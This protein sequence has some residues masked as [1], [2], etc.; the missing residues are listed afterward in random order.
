MRTQVRL[1]CP[2]HRDLSW[3]T[4]E[5][6]EDYAGAQIRG[7]MAPYYCVSKWTGDD[8]VRAMIM[9]EMLDTHPEFEQLKEELIDEFGIE[10]FIGKPKP[11]EYHIRQLE[12]AIELCKTDDDRAKL[13]KELREYRGWTNKP[14]EKAVEVTIN[15][16][17]AQISFDKNNPSEVERGVMSFFG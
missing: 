7:G 11:K 5:L 2:F 15:N 3:L 9:P 13:Y 16:N 1:Y 17:N 12:I 4:Q 8:K 6:I 14:A 10:H